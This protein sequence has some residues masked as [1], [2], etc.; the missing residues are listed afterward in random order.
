MENSDNEEPLVLKNVPPILQNLTMFTWNALL[1]EEE[2]CISLLQDMEL[3]PRKKDSPLCPACGSPMAALSHSSYIL[4]WRWMCKKRKDKN[5]R[6]F[7][8]VSPLQNTFFEHNKLPFRDVL[9][10]IFGF[11]MKVSGLQLH[12]EITTWRIQHRQERGIN[13]NTVCFHYH[14]F[15]RIGITIMKYSRDSELKEE[16][17]NDKL[18]EEY[19]KRLSRLPFFNQRVF[20]FL[21]DIKPVFPGYGKVGLDQSFLDSTS[22]EADMD[23][24]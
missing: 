12:R 10:I 2:K 8:S 21:L 16:T 3:I 22:A 17:S 23:S 6:C 20:Q 7:K 14:R 9:A 19:Y 18:L 5:A 15:K 4:K 11:I 1:D 24:E 13:H